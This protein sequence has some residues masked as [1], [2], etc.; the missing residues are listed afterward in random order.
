M[1]KISAKTRYESFMEWHKWAKTKYPSMNV[2]KKKAPVPVWM[3][4]LGDEY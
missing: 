4:N 2:K 1:S 3:G